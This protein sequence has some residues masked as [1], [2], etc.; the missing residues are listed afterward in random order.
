MCEATG[1]RTLSRIGIIVCLAVSLSAGDPQSWDAMAGDAEQIFACRAP[2]QERY[3]DPASAALS[4][5]QKAIEAVD[6]ST[7]DNVEER[8][9]R[10]AFHANAVKRSMELRASQVAAQAALEQASKLYSAGHQIQAAS[11]LEKAV[12]PACW[13]AA[14]ELK[15]KIESARRE[16]GVQFDHALLTLERGQKSF[17]LKAGPNILRD[18][19]AALERVKGLDADDPRSGILIAETKVQIANFSSPSKYEVLV[20]SNPGGARLVLNTGDGEK[21]CE[22]TPCKFRFDEAYFRR[23]GGSFVNS[24]RMLSPAVATITKDGYEPARLSLTE[25]KGTWR[26]S[27]PGRKIN[28]TYYYFTKSRFQIWLRPA[29]Q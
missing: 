16:A 7:S 2:A 21:V 15:S 23:S 19:V 22:K 28:E 9:L 12:L 6:R 10:G 3:L 17:D 26:A 11:A 4:L 8:A 29:A 13:V 1:K 18:A 14:Q 20:M 24:K 27:L 25:G 5:Y